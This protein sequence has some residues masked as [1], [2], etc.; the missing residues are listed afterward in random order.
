MKFNVDSDKFHDVMR[1]VLPSSE[2]MNSSLIMRKIT[3]KISLEEYFTKYLTNA[4][5]IRNI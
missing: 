1:M 5:K 4:I 3:E 2:L